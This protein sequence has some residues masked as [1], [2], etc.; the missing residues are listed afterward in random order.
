MNKICVKLLILTVLIFVMGCQ[1]DQ[2]KQPETYVI[3]IQNLE[4]AKAKYFAGDPDYV[5]AVD[6]LLV[7]CVR[8]SA[9]GLFSV[10]NKTVMPPSGDKHD[11]YSFGPYWWPD[12]TKPDGLPYIRR[13][14]ER[15]PETRSLKFDRQASRMM[16]RSVFP[17]ALAYYFTGEEKY[18]KHATQLIRTWFIDAETKMNPNLDY[19]QAI[20]GVV[21][22]RGIGIIESVEFIYIIEAIGLIESSKSFNE[23]DK[24]AM[25]QWFDAY[26]NWMMT[27]KNGIDED[28]WYNNHGT[29]Y[30]AQKIDYALFV[31]KDSL[32]QA[33]AEK[34]K[35]RR[36][37]SQIEPDG[38]M[39]HELKRTRSMHYSL[40][41]LRAFFLIA[42][43]AENFN[44]DLWHYE[45]EDGRSI[46]KALDYLIPYFY[47]KDDWPYQQITPFENIYR[48]L[49]R[50]L[51]IANDKYNDSK[52][53]KLHD[54]LSLYKNYEQIN[55][56]YPKSGN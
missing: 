4:Y 19:A 9:L 20:P 25:V 24:Q 47:N 17:H 10:M 51:R 44:I 21:D 27:S 33:T 12:T 37:A 45:T 36:L 18:A 6:S 38:K 32:A 22:G 35:I 8:M 48:D 7:E 50:I 34:S 16:M 52:Y 43:L 1:S 46:K 3:P 56:L 49:D 29:Y 31:G 30:D 40:Y 54:D 55:L 2:S 13:D 39:L 5:V 11:Y 42:E 41:N 15:N 28:N 14:G 53:K 26:L 23:N